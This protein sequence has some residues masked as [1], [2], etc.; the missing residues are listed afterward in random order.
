MQGDGATTRRQ[1]PAEDTMRIVQI[2]TI[3]TAVAAIGL[4]LAACGT[5]GTAGVAAPNVP[6]A[7]GVVTTVAPTTP[8]AAVVVATQQAVPVVSTAPVAPPVQPPAQKP[9]LK[10]VVTVGPVAHLPVH[11]HLAPLNLHTVNWANVTIPGTF[12]SVPGTVH[13][14]G[15]T[16]TAVSTDFGHV[17]IIVTGHP[18]YG[19]LDGNGHD[20]AALPVW[21]NNG[22][23]TADGDLAMGYVVFDGSSGILTVVGTLTPKVHESGAP[24]SS[25]AALT[26]TPEHIVAKEMY[27]HAADPTCCPTGT[28]KT[29]WLLTNGHLVAGPSTIIS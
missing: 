2:T 5:T 20:V 27:F 6:A 15:N 17:Q 3:A 7:V 16:A 8:A 21:C 1:E 12:C 25:I 13:L 11:L 18:T 14:T 29:T 22:G 19:D 23:G 28:A 10:K 24:I 4:G 26:I 9:A